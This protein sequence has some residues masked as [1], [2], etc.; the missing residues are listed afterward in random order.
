MS[1]GAAFVADIAAPDCLEVAFVRSPVAHGVLK[2][3][4]IGPDGRPAWSRHAGHIA[5]LSPIRG[6]LL[7]DNFNGAPW[8]LLATGKVRFVGE[9][10]ALVM[11]PTRAQAEEWAAQIAPRIEPLPAVVSARAEFE[12]PTIPLHENLTSNVIMQTARATGEYD[13]VVAEAASRNLR[14]VR[15]RFLMDRVLASL[16]ECRGVPGAARQGH[17]RRPPAPCRRS[18]RT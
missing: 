9:A 13:S 8:P 1:G 14:E 5:H 7:R 4:D 3:I 15:R 16:L 10:V 2:G 6:E 18:A 17:R 12:H 11:A